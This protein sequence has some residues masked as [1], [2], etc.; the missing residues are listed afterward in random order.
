MVGAA[1]GGG[2]VSAPVFTSEVHFLTVPANA[3]VIL[4]VH[5][6]DP[7]AGLGA[8]TLSVQSLD[9]VV[10]H[11]RYGD[12]VASELTA[13][14]PFQMFAFEAAGGDTVTINVDSDGAFDSQ[15]RLLLPG[16]RRCTPTTTAVPAT[17]RKSA[18][19]TSRTAALTTSWCSR[20]GR[21]RWAASR[22][23]SR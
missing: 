18:T 22:S 20:R 9:A 8:F 2:P 11:V 21:A 5:G 16:A 3:E 1:G 4:N 12:V 14:L 13:D 15:L 19:S 10:T 23:A 6:I 7:L 17:I